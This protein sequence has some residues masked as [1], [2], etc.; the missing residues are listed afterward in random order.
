MAFD[1]HDDTVTCIQHDVHVDELI[2]IELV[3]VVEETNVV[4]AFG[5]ERR[6][7]LFFLCEFHLDS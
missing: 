5:D 7:S 2:F 6:S 1:L 3:L 4:G